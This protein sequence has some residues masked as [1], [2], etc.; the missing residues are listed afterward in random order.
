MVAKLN[1]ST[2]SDESTAKGKIKEV[3]FEPRQRKRL[4]DSLNIVTPRDK[5][6]HLNQ[7]EI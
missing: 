2:S 6:D 4:L 3:V 7:L 5:W 1:M